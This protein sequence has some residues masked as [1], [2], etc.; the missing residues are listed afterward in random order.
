MDYYQGVVSEY[1]RADRSV[2]LNSEFCLQ[3]HP[4]S[5]YDKSSFWYVDILA[6]DL[7]NQRAFLCEITYSKTL[8]ALKKRLALWSQHWPEMREAL[9]RDAGIP[10]AWSAKPWLFVPENL[11]TPLVAAV[12][13]LTHGSEKLPTPRIT[14]LEHTQ[15]WRYVSWD[16]KGEDTKPDC[17]PADMRD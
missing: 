9:E 12:N 3:L 16:R 11:V 7:R 15:P 13:S 17:I 1:L 14:T 10:S 4:G 2:F 5:A 8:S 6:I